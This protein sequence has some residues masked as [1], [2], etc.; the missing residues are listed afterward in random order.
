MNPPRQELTRLIEKGIVDGELS[1]E[2]RFGNCAGALLG[3][4]LY[5]YIFCGDRQESRMDWRRKW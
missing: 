4:I 5:W 2:N 3:P 1:K